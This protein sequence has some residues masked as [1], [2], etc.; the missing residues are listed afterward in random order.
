MARQILK[1]GLLTFLCFAL[2]FA[3]M[4]APN[5][6]ARGGGHD[7]GHNYG[8]GYGGGHYYGYGHGDGHYYY[9]G[10][11]WHDSN[12]WWPLAWFTAAFTIGTVVATLPPHYQTIYV[13]G[14][15]YPYYYYDG[16]YF[17]PYRAGG[18]VVVPSPASTTVVTTAPAVITPAAAPSVTQPSAAEGETVVINI[19]NTKGGYTPITL[20]KYKTGYVGPQ[21]EYYEGH[22]TVDQ[23]KVLYGN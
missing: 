16:A 8:H 15:P 20:K 7:G 1:N 14:A 13:S 11:Y 23:L 10:G 21:G 4:C 5:A 18:Y 2:A 17:T 9:H 12:W 19:P 6:W 22:P 3:P